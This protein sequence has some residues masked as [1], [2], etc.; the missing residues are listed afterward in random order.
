LQQANDQ[1]E[2]RVRE[3]TLE[4]QK[5][6]LD[7]IFTLTRAA[8]H[9]DQDT[10]HHVQR[11]SYYSRELATRLGMG[12]AFIE[13]IFFASPMHDIGKIGIPDH[14]LLKPSGLTPLEWKVMRAHCAMGARILGASQSPFLRMGAEIAQNHHECWDGAGYPKGRKG[15]AIPLAA[16]IMNVCDIYD[17]L[18]SKRPYKPALGHAKV[19]DIILHGDGRTSPEHF[20]PA[21]LGVFQTHQE[22]F[23]DIFE[24]YAK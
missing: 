16:R 7:T 23:R 17:A 9:K 8:E 12:E 24:A 5:S 21:I 15:E 11:I 22:T 4:L 20:D 10:G 19:M 6:Y 1:L 14:I 2:K 18:R 13:Q 3:R